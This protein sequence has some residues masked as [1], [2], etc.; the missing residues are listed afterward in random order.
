VTL[1]TV[2]YGDAVPMTVGGR[3]V[4]CITMLA[5]IIILA[6]PI[7]VIGA[8]FTQ[9]WIIYKD[10]EKMKEQAVTL[11]PSYLVRPHIPALTRRS[12]PLCL[13]PGSEI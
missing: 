13:Q 10:E 1:M 7:S 9:Q 12:V 3:V 8:N 6:L 4:A 11:K 5:S 2:G